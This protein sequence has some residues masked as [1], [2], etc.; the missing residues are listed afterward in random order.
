M[1]VGLQWCLLQ[2]HLNAPF[3][4]GLCFYA[5]AKIKEKSG[6]FDWREAVCAERRRPKVEVFDLG[7]THLLSIF[8][9]HHIW[10]PS[11]QRAG[12]GSDRNTTT[13]PLLSSAH[14]HT[15]SVKL[16]KK[17]IQQIWPS[18]H[19]RDGLFWHFPCIAFF[20]CPFHPLSMWVRPRDKPLNKYQVIKLHQPF[21]IRVFCLIPNCSWIFLMLSW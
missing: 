2:T 3:C 12:E 14:A 8:Y 4:A 20:L 10:S 11:C 6:P 7:F 18:Q 19:K 9:F 1:C 13:P 15:G 17:A 21:V 16:C 5:E